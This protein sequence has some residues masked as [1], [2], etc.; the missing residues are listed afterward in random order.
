MSNT[1]KLVIV[2][3]CDAALSLP[4]ATTGRVGEGEWWIT[5]T[6]ESLEVNSRG[7]VFVFGMT[8]L[9]FRGW[10]AHLDF[11]FFGQ[12]IFWLRWGSQEKEIIY[13]YWLFKKIEID[14]F[15]FCVFLWPLK[16]YITSNS[17]YIN[18]FFWKL[19]KQSR[20]LN[21]NMYYI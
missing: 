6:A 5:T 20:P 7:S 14:I 11:G 9:P 18:W 17:K 12:R 21:Y 2:K 19:N 4:V 13:F 3:Y 1:S 16:W 8:T 10:W 15:C